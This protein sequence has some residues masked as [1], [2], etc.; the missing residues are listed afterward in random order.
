MAEHLTIEL[1][2]PMADELRSAVEAGR[3]ASTNEAVQDA[4]QLWSER[5]RNERELLRAAW[6]EGKASGR[7]GPL[8]FQGLRQEARQRLAAAKG[9]DD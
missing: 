6:D 9:H 7:H 3:Y 8:D 2:V 5:Q 1:P 4:V